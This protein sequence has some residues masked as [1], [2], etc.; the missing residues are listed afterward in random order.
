[1][2]RKS[3]FRVNEFL[4]S[5]TIRSEQNPFQ[6]RGQA[7][8][9]GSVLHVRAVFFLTYGVKLSQAWNVS[10]G[11]Q[12]TQQSSLQNFGKLKIYMEITKTFKYFLINAAAISFFIP[13][14]KTHSS[15]IYTA[16]QR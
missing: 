8:V 12:S 16:F 5:L 3:A 9:L 10:F 7:K 14:H 6:Q 4:G 1:M 2:A 11:V 13:Q 15:N